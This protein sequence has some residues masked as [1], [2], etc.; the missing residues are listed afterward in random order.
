M[1]SI[2]SRYWSCYLKMRHSRREIDNWEELEKRIS[3]KDISN[4]FL[5]NG[6]NMSLGVNTSY[7][8]LFLHLIEYDDMKITMNEYEGLV[9]K[10]RTNGYNLEAYK[11]EILNAG[12][13]ASVTKEFYRTILRRCKAHYKHEEVVCFLGHFN[14]YFTTNYDPLIYRFLLQFKKEDVDTRSRFYKDIKDVHSGEVTNLGAFDDRPLRA[15]A[16][17]QVYNLALLIFKD[18]RIHY[19]RKRDEYYAALKHIRNE[20]EFVVQDGFVINPRNSKKLRSDKKF[21]TWKRGNTDQ[22]IFYLHGAFHIYE[23]E[24]EVRKVILAKNY[25]EQTFVNHLLDTQKIITCVFEKTFKEKLK[26]INRNPYLS[27]CRNKL[28]ET[29]GQMVIIGWSCSESDKHLIDTI[30]KSKIHTLYVSYY[31]TGEQEKKDM[32]KRFRNYFSSKKIFFFPVEILPF[33]KK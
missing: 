29:S 28:E 8:S 18:R 10:I 16:K 31:Q 6:F 22:N 2:L 24:K 14:K 33:Y 4:I 17:R 27:Y 15:I 1:F 32:K 25:R 26:K 11:N 23:S 9:E 13:R 12:H 7:E 5:G 30:K 19:E 21:R 20:K 3:S